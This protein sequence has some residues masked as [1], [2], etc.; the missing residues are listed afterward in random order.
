MHT[1][2]H[3]LTR[4]QSCSPLHIHAPTHIHRDIRPHTYPHSCAWLRVRLSSSRIWLLC[5]VQLPSSNHSFVWGQSSA[6]SWTHMSAFC[7]PLPITHQ[8]QTTQ[9]NRVAAGGKWHDPS[10][11]EWDPNDFRIFVGDL[12]NEVSDEG[13]AR[14]F[15]QYQSLVKAK[16]GAFCPCLLRPPS[17]V[18]VCSSRGRPPLPGPRHSRMGVVLHV[19]TDCAGCSRQEVGQGTGLWLCFVQGPCRLHQG[20]E[21]NAWWVCLYPERHPS[22]TFLL[23]VVSCAESPLNQSREALD[24]IGP[25]LFCLAINRRQAR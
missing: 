12:G 4:L 24:P 2:A 11:D 3:T 6:L 15:Q 1:H 7:I 9:A 21:G 18:S 22:H 13:L 23:A 8:P 17:L 16:V 25:H 10:L 20:H 19:L 14:A 5:M